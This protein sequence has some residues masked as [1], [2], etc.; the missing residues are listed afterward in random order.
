MKNSFLSSKSFK[1]RAKVSTGIVLVVL[2]GALTPNVYG[3][4][5]VYIAATIL[6]LIEVHTLAIATEQ[7]SWQNI[8]HVGFVL[9]VLALSIIAVLILPKTWL[10]MG[11]VLTMASDVGAYMVGKICGR[12]FIKSRPFP[13]VSPNKSWE[14][15]IGGLLIPGLIA[16]ICGYALRDDLLSR[17]L[18][19]AV[20]CLAGICA[21]LGDTC[22]SSLKRH[23]GVK[24]ANDVLKTKPV[25]RHVEALLG[26]SEG[27]GGYYD[28]L[29]SM[30]IVLLFLGIITVLLTFI[31][32]F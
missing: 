18:L 10:I 13:T 16:P 21:I 26:G 4:R 25:F 9:L 28:R 24:D 19:V 32:S 22:E 14:G 7:L 17:P 6:S 23:L 1:V 31:S 2:I 11:I 15:V 27:H 30:S 20:G 8:C 12:R 3:L 5:A 29:D